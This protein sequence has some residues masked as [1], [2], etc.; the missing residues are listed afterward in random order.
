VD[1]AAQW[2]PLGAVESILAH[3]AGAAPAWLAAGVALHLA[4]QAARGLAWRGALG[5][6]AGGAAVLCPR[7][8][9][10]CW[11]AGAGLSGVLSSRGGD[12]VRLGLV[13]R[14]VPGVPVAALAGTLVVEGAFETVTGTLLGA[15]ALS[16]GIAAVGPP[17]AA[18]AVPLVA[19]VVLLA[20]LCAVPATRR[21]LRRQAR[22]AAAGLALLRRPR[23]YARGVLPFAAL[24]RAL[25]V[26]SVGCF[27]AAFALPVGLA[28]I[29]CV[30]AAQGSA[31]TAP[32]PGVGTAA[33]AGLLV[34]AFGPV[35]GHA[36][37]PARLV[38]F[39]VGVPALLTVVGISLSAALAVWLLGVGS[40]VRAWR[41]LRG[42]AEAAPEPAA[43][44][45]P[46][47]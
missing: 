4:A 23:A 22:A 32:A 38:A 15:W 46:A 41:G 29:A 7:R 20:G 35:T 30:A 14:L 5:P 10:A 24:S 43:L 47:P 13:R 36:V 28:A 11:I 31:R 42:L 12:V 2:V 27:L 17:G 45:A 16:R 3:L 6:L 40:P 26:L 1:G 44:R 19:L 18:Q 21:W 39:A 37:D 9:A 34:V 8:V 25:R 33:G